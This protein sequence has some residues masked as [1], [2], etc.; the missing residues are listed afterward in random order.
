MLLVSQRAHGL[1]LKLMPGILRMIIQASLPPALCILLSCNISRPLSALH[2]HAYQQPQ[3][4]T[5]TLSTPA[6]ACGSAMA[7]AGH[8]VQ[9][10]MQLAPDFF[11]LFAATSPLLDSDPS[12]YCVSSWN[13]H[14]Q[15]QFV[16]DPRR[17]LR[18][19]F[20]P[21]L[22]WMLT[23]DV[24]HDIRW[25]RNPADATCQGPCAHVLDAT[26]LS[27]GHG[28]HCYFYSSGA[29]ISRVVRAYGSTMDSRC[30]APGKPPM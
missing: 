9:D 24:W 4:L 7:H 19:D 8:L 6:P 22:G 3:A 15:K 21:G 27:C 10:D 1:T 2:L 20:F 12:L 17:L 11:E 14:G 16:A 5:K 30:T 25:I 18:S 28:R 23:R 13:D 29:S 26:S